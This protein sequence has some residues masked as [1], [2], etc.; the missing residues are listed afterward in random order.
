[1]YKNKVIF[2]FNDT[3]AGLDTQRLDQK[4]NYN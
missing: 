2:T 3:G 1:M 4:I